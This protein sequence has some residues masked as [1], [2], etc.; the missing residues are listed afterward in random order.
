MRARNLKPGLFKNELLGS[1]E[2][3]ITILFAGLWCSADREGRLE[4][5]PLRLC[6]EVFPYRRKVT[7]RKVNAWLDWLHEHKFIVRYTVSEK[8]FI[9]VVEFLSHQNPHRDERHSEIPALSSSSHS[10]STV[11]APCD[12]DKSPDVVRLNPESG[13]LN[14]E[15]SL[16]ERARAR[17]VGALEGKGDLGQQTAG[18]WSGL[19]AWRDAGCDPEAMGSWLA[20]LAQQTPPKHLPAHARIHAA[21]ILASF[22][23][24]DAQ[25]RTVSHAIANNW[26]SLRVADG[27]RPAGGGKR[28]MSERLAALQTPDDEPEARTA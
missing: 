27:Q 1:A 28:T 19:D 8:R 26:K 16:R 25:R 11:E 17:G 22:G 4:D 14:P 6:A 7:E 13:I 18:A 24:A 9:Q 10:A 2:P 20:H 3:L 15:S 21:K 12:L 23:D 5:R